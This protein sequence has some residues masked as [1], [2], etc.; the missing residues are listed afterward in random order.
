MTVS[1]EDSLR[2]SIDMQ[3]S[4]G[5][6]GL[7]D[8]ALMSAVSG[9]PA[10]SSCPAVPHRLSLW[11]HPHTLQV[12]FRAHESPSAEGLLA[13]ALDRT[14]TRL[15]SSSRY[16]LAPSTITS[17]PPLA[18]FRP[19][20]F[21]RPRRFPPSPALRVYFTPQPRPGFTLQGFSPSTSTTGSSPAVALLPFPLAPCRCV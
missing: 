16:Q 14:P 12:S 4:T 17:F 7:A 1:R 13:L 19:R 18:S 20:R 11:V 3:N 10:R 5:L 6:I 9:A 2:T 15:P 21:A 8:P